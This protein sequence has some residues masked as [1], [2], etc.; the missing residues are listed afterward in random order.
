MGCD[1]LQSQQI[2]FHESHNSIYGNN[3]YVIILMHCLSLLLVSLLM[4]NIIINIIVVLR[5]FDNIYI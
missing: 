4:Q 2:P 5:M 1:S 3:L